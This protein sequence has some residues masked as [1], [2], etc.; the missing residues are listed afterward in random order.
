MGNNEK[1]AVSW[2]NILSGATVLTLLSAFLI[3]HIIILGDSMTCCNP[4]VVGCLDTCMARSAVWSWVT[5]VG[6]ATLFL[7]LLATILYSVNKY[8]ERPSLL[9]PQQRDQ[10]YLQK[11]ENQSN[12]FSYIIEPTGIATHFLG[13]VLNCGLLA[14]IVTLVVTVYL[15]LKITDSTYLE[16]LSYGYFFVV[17]FEVLIGWTTIR[18]IALFV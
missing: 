2:C 12:H 11:T 16:M 13:L 5:I 8:R 1:Y 9:L 15:S 3:I 10:R 7:V 14:L 17:F 18:N 6:C 4:S